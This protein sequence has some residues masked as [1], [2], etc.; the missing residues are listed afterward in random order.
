MKL[1]PYLIPYTKINS[2]W[3]KG[4]NVRPE[5]VKLLEENV[6]VKLHDIGLGND[7]MNMTPKAQETKTKTKMWEYVKLK[8][9]RT[10]K[11]IVNSEKTTYRIG[12]NIW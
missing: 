8:G 1:D 5:N 6:E 10:A 9:F 7:F 2:E 12:E 4:L 11:E 3:I